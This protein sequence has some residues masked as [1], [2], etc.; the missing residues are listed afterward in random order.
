MP[1]DKLNSDQ[2]RRCVFA[3]PYRKTSPDQFVREQPYIDI[4]VPDDDPPEAFKEPVVETEHDVPLSELRLKG[5]AVVRVYDEKAVN[6]APTRGTF[7][8]GD[9]LGDY[10][11]AQ[12]RCDQALESH[13]V[14]ILDELSDY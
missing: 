10:Y 1:V 6:P 13:G 11:D 9:L 2:I 4:H 14:H 5:R 12:D 7:E 3:Q 8:S